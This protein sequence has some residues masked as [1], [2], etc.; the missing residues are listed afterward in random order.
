MGP[1]HF[2]RR[3]GPE[4]ADVAVD[5]IGMMLSDSS[6]DLL[7]SV[8]SAGVVS[9]K[10]RISR[11]SSWRVRCVCC[12][13]KKK[14]RPGTLPRTGTSERESLSDSWMRPPMATVRPSLATMVPVKVCSCTVSTGTEVK[15]EP[16]AFGTGMLPPLGMTV[17][18]FC[19]MAT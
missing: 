16:L 1:K 9:T 7:V 13:R 5:D 10:G 14:P 12:W 6:S 4:V 18:L 3:V 17:E 15:P 2:G 19:R 11:T 8:D